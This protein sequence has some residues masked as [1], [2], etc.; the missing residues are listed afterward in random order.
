MTRPCLETKARP[1][2]RTWAKSC[3]RKKLSKLAVFLQ[4]L[5]YRFDNSYR[6]FK[7]RLVID[8]MV[9]HPAYW[10]RGHASTVANWFLD[11][12]RMDQRG[13][14]VAGA[15]MGK[16]FFSH[17]GFEEARTVEIPGYDAHPK[18]IYAWLGLLNVTGEDTSDGQDEL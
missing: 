5:S 12:A 7:G 15:P 13:V 4:D 1:A 16:L 14:G 11:M 9:T 17:L 2:P 18:P 8:M 10:R 6:T 3:T